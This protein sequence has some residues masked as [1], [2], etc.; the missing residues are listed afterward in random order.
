MSL[1]KTAIAVA[2]LLLA[3][4]AGARGQS[5]TGAAG[6]R[7]Y[8]ALAPVDASVI[9][10]LATP[11]VP[12]PTLIFAAQSARE[13]T[14]W[15]LPSKVTEWKERPSN[16]QLALKWEELNRNWYGAK[17]GDTRKSVPP[18]DYQPY[19]LL[20]ISARDWKDLEK[21]ME[22]E[23]AKHGAG[24]CYD[25]Q[26]ATYL[27]VAGAVRNPVAAT[28]GGQTRTLQY[29]QNAGQAQPEGIGP[30][31]HSATSTGHSAIGDEFDASSGTSDPAVYACVYLFR[32]AGTAQ[33]TSAGRQA[34]PDLYYCHA[35]SGL[36]SSLGT[37]LKYVAKQ[38]L[39]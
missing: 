14:E 3:S 28:S 26:R 37:M 16:T 5:A 36:R 25:E 27:F 17:P 33:G 11:A 22:K 21:W 2:G 39:P 7:A 24:L 31:G 30:G 12:P 9:R 38:G 15:D 19:Q 29:A 34:V 20:Q 32:T 10:L 6:C 13:L 4:A 23:T 35:A 18:A 8:I 1:R